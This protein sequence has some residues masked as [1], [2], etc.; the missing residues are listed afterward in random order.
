MFQ[1][2]DKLNTRTGMMQYY[3]YIP[4]ITAY[5][6]FYV[7][8]ILNKTYFSLLNTRFITKTILK[9]PDQIDKGHLMKN[10]VTCHTLDVD[11]CTKATN[12][13]SD[14]RG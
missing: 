7:S 3:F 11:L 2:C 12:L 8:Q 9:R 4:V 6:H 5:V 14:S 1:F 13:T 10:R